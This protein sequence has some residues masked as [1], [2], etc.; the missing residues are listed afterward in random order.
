MSLTEVVTIG[1]YGWQA[2]DFFR[3]LQAAGVDTFCDV[4]ARRGLRGSQYAFGNSRRLQDSLAALGIPYLHRPDLAPSQATRQGQ[5]AADRA[6]R[7]TKR[8]RAAVSDDFAAEYEREV[9]GV[10]DPQ[11]F[12]EGLGPQARIA[13]LFCVEARPA[14]CHRSLLAGR[15][16]SSLGL[17]VTHLTPPDLP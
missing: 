7:V 14:A 1:A 13:A 10:F 8:G 17:K 4:R 15:L 12:V 6:A 5:Y 16:G 11:A 2:E 3:A 9:L